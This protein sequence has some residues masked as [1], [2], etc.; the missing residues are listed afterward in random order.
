MSAATV[1]VLRGPVV[2]IDIGGTGVVTGLV[3]P[4]F[5]VPDVGPLVRTPTPVG[6]DAILDACIRAVHE[7]T[8]GTPATAI[9]VGAPGVIDPGSGTV[10]A[11]SAV[12]PDWSGVRVADVL[13]AATGLPVVVENDVR[14]FCRGEAAYG[15]GRAFGRCLYVS[16]GTGIG[17]AVSIDGEVRTSPRGTIGELAHLSVPGVGHHPCGCGSR[18]HLESVASG[19]AMAA[20][21]ARRTGARG[22]LTLHDVRDALTAGDPVAAGVVDEA[23]TLAGECLAGVVGAF[24]LDAVV[25]GG[26]ALGVSAGF[27]GQVGRALRA[28][29]WPRGRD[30][31]IAE[32]ELGAAGPVIGAA[33]SAAALST[34]GVD[35]R[36]W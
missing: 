20:A 32:R 29:I 12:I 33:L 4:G 6:P 19:P 1:P 11:A 24:D 17:G 10:L 3:R 14:A 22:S 13:R 30:V 36:S 2:G 28:G 25:L 23:A 27:A 7:V 16:F 26:G 18:T 31:G 34:P 35:G 15:A 21:Y 8:T 9:G 5:H